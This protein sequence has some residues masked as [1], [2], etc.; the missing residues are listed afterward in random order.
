[1]IDDLSSRPDWPEDHAAK[2][3]GLLEELRQQSEL[4][5]WPIN[6]E[7]WDHRGH[8]TLT[9]RLAILALQARGI[10][11]IPVCGVAVSLI[12]ILPFARAKSGHPCPSNHSFFLS[13]SP[14]V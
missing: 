7:H 4:V 12:E 14:T 10:R 8:Q 9:K 11:S 1:M 6:W 3:E 2:I 13:R 5:M